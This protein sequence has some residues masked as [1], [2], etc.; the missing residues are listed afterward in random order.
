MADIYNIAETEKKIRNFWEKNNIYK[1]DSKRNKGKEIYSIDTPPPTV[2]GNMHMGHPFSYSQQDFI[3]RYRRMT[4]NVF[5]PFGT[6]DNGLPTE[7]LIEKLK[8]IKSKDMSREEFIRICLKTLQEIT[9]DFISDWKKL[10]ISCDYD[11]K[12]ST[13]DDNS[14]KLSQQ[15]F[16]ELYKKGLAYKK[17][18]PT[19][20]CPECQTPIAQAEL[21]DKKSKTLFSTLKFS[22]GGKDLLIATTRPE[23]LGAC[24]CVFVNPEDKRYKNLIGKKALVP[25]FEYE[26]SIIADKSA[27]MEKG[28][29]V[30]MVCSFGDKYDVDA[31]NRHKL[32]PRL[33]L[34]KDGKL[35]LG[36]YEGM[37]I[38]EARG[39]ILSELKD[40][41]LIKEQKEIEHVVNVHDKCGTPIEFLT[42]EQWFIKILDK[43]N[44]F[45]KQAEKIKWKPE[46]ML[47]RYKNWVLGLEWDWSISRERHFGIPIPVW[48]CKECKEV[49]LAIEKELPV[50]PMQI[51]KKCPSP[52]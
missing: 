31:I 51:K 43:K 13:I 22:C 48:E 36:K 26:V 12:Y 18:F 50:D 42:T 44:E 32:T 2:S 9:P 52:D 40:K 45:I 38:K 34:D 17:N 49:I 19:I 37:K 39:K 46:Y 25:L 16:I 11:I 47:K 4:G 1:F 3:A 7:R 35:N 14:R 30:L 33:I 21:E 20:W 27:D 6:D 15:Y 8:N 23:L 10:G 24:V 28:T 41:N 29:G 5:Y